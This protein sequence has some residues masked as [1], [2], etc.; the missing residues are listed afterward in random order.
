M[1]GLISF[2]HSITVSTSVSETRYRFSVV[3]PN[4][5]ARILICPS[6]SSPETYKIFFFLHR[7]F[8]KF[9]K[10][11]LIYRY[12]GHRL[13][14]LIHPVQ[15]RRQALCQAPVNR[16]CNVFHIRL[17]HHRFFFGIRTLPPLLIDIARVADVFLFR[18][19]SFLYGV[20]TVTAWAFSPATSVICTHIHCI[21]M[22]FLFS[23]LFLSFISI[24][25]TKN[26]IHNFITFHP[27]CQATNITLTL[28]FA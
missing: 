27:H 22:S 24:A 25:T 14:V 15:F 6:D 28:R 20:P 2:I 11:M 3:T 18:N 10:V 12:P 8:G 5:S 19:N 17:L 4:L 21:Y 13:Q 26:Y 9:A 7:L 1:S 23:F 16:F